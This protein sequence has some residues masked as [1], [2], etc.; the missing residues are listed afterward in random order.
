MVYK[1]KFFINTY[2]EPISKKGANGTV[3]AVAFFVVLTYIC[4]IIA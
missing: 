3:L 4:R 2:A 1:K